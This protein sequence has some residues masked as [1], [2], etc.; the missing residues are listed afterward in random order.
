[1]LTDLD[2]LQ[3]EEIWLAQEGNG[4]DDTDKSAGRPY[5]V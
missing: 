1:M 3:E 4:V 5:F 2:L